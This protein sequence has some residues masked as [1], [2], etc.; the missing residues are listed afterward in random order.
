TRTIEVR[1]ALDNR[2]GRLRP[3]MTAQVRIEDADARPA[4]VVPTE[5]VIRTGTRTMVIVAN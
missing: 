3:G 5:A 4:L 2:Q 1:L